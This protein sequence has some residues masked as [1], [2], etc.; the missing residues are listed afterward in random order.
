MRYSKAI[1]ICEKINDIT[2]TTDEEKLEAIDK[3]LH[4]A[5]INAVQKHVLQNIVLWFWVRCVTE[6]PPKED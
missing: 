1:K 3:I 4:M 2:D 6:E 5:T